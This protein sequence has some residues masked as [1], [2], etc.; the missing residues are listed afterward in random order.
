MTW[1]SKPDTKPVDHSFQ[2]VLLSEL[3]HLP[4]DDTGKSDSKRGLAVVSVITLVQDFWWLG[5][6][7][8]LPSP[9]TTA[10]KIVFS[11]GNTGWNDIN[12]ILL[13]MS[14]SQASEVPALGRHK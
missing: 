2:E 9:T 6:A 12:K 7:S 8:L 4:L 3:M 10:S 14:C 1:P 5:W 13:I 11:S